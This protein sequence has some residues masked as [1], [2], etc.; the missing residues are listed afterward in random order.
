MLVRERAARVEAPLLAA[1]SD[2]DPPAL[3]AAVEHYPRAGGKR[4]RP[5]IAL[6]AAEAAGG[7]WERAM[8]VAVA[9]ELVHV[10]SLVHDD[11]MDGDTLRRGLP[12]VHARWGEPV[13]IL[14]GDALLAKAFEALTALDARA[15]QDA[16]RRASEATR[17]L[18]AGQ[19]MDMAFEA[20]EDV[21]PDDYLEMIQHKTAALFSFAASGGALVAGPD[22]AGVRPFQEWGLAFG[23]A[24]QLRDDLLDVTADAATLGK[25][26]GK[27]VRAGKK[28]LLLLEARR[29]AQGAD[30]AT[31]ARVVG[32]ADAG[33]DEVAR[34]VDVYRRTG[35]L[36]VVED[37]TREHAKRAEAAL[38]PLP[39]SG[40]RD[41]LGALARWSA[42]R[43]S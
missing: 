4:L 43:G 35:A 26:A 23:L 9:A 18:C 33:A 20:R 14:A 37:A 34:V 3:R 29:R 2:I 30:A 6:L 28:T 36:G 19:A 1:L 21:A 27:D 31:L 12:T 32:K 10:F 25:T 40:A 38:A 7:D 17:L 39:P 41:A 11:I 22:R 42:T 5:A 15:S 13:G 16:V 24:F 8:P